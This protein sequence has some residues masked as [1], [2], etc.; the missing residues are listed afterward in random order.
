VV[1]AVVLSAA[2]GA[3]TVV[4][5]GDTNPA[6]VR[7]IQAGGPAALGGDPVHLAAWERTD[8]T[9]RLDLDVVRQVCLSTDGG[10]N[11]TDIECELVSPGGDG[12]AVEAEFS[13]ENDDWPKTGEQT[14][15]ISVRDSDG[16]VITE[17]ERPVRVVA[18]DGDVDEDGLTNEREQTIG[19]NF[20][21]ADT[22]GDGLSDG[23]EVNVHGTDP[24]LNDTDDD[25]L[26]D[27]VEVERGSNPTVA[28]TDD[29]GLEDGREVDLGTDPTVAD[30][31]GDGLE[32]RREVDLGTDPTTADS[33]GDGLLDGEEVN[34]RDTDPTRPDTDSDGLPDG[35]EVDIG[36]N[37]TVADT[38]GD[39]LDDGPERRV[40]GTDP[41][42]ADTD[43]DGRD[44]AAEVVAGSGGEAV[45]IGGITLPVDAP[46]LG[47]ALGLVGLGVVMALGWYWRRG[48]GIEVE[49]DPDVP[50]ESAAPE[51]A[52]DSGAAAV[53]DEPV[54]DEGRVVRLLTD[55]G[56][57]MRQHEIVEATDWSKSK[58][59]RLLSR[60]DE[61][62]Q[63][64]KIRLGRENLVTLPEAEPD[65][66]SGSS[67][68]ACTRPYR[69]AE[70]GELGFGTSKPSGAWTGP[71]RPSCA[72]G[73]GRRAV[74]T[75]TG[76]THQP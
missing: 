41:T 13:V 4:G 58:V 75:A 23:D 28:D 69:R 63:I 32:D 39:G 14:L 17:A 68:S 8:V 59:S 21:N 35:R 27:G 37:P 36:T 44:D 30:T 60:M 9:A 61:E 53:A 12:T 2:L 33:D 67:Q 1:L 74:R 62:G 31:D 10:E 76:R 66:V 52:P 72:V 34:V 50:S 5:S 47:G 48:G 3:G 6:A 38:D 55:S 40:H 42:L 15:Y 45:S 71:D 19:S 64:R 70:G 51:T 18:A 43:G 29:D 49:T 25:E 7:G 56:G 24:T 22:D 54:T 65:V 26:L 20:T 16:G 73:W 57:R 11:R 46:L